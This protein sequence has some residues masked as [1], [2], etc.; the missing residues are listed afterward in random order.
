[1]KHWWQFI[2]FAVVGFFSALMDYCVL[3]I[4]IQCCVGK[5]LALT[6]AFFTGVAVNI[7]LHAQITFKSKLMVQNSI[8]FLDY[9]K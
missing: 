4:C 1:M 3:L 6:F 7:W 2:T 5:Y 9:G 8:R